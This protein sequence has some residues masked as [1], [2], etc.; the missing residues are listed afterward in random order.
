TRVVGGPADA[1]PAPLRI[2]C[3]G[4]VDVEVNVDGGEPVV[5][6]RLLAGLMSMIVV[7]FVRLGQVQVDPVPVGERVPF[8]AVRSRGLEPDGR[9]MGEGG[10][11]VANREHGAYPGE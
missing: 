6:V 7:V 2:Q 9:V 11:Q 5:V 3:V 10:L 4:V 8:T 1:G